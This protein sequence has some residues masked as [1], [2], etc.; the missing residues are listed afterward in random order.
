MFDKLIESEPAG[1]EFHGRK[2]Y[3]LVS[4]VVMGVLF[5]TAVVYSIYA[6]DIGLGTENFYLTAMIAPVPEAE[7]APEIERRRQSSPASTSTSAVP[8]RKSVMASID[9]PTIAPDSVSVSKNTQLAR[10]TFGDYKIGPDDYEPGMGAGSAR[11]AGEP[12][13]GPP[14]ALTAARSAEIEPAEVA[15]PPPPAKKVDTKPATPSLGVINGRASYL[16]KPVYSAA[17][18][19][20]Q[21]KGKVDVQVLIDEEGKVVSAKAVSGHPLLRDAAVKAAQNARFTP[22]LLSRVPIKVTGVIV[23]NFTR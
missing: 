8:M 15:P 23:Y 14:A 22:T 2:R 6:G 11:S 20:V 4:S 10:P 9:D 21:A 17:A 18:I 3:F 13:G 5:T 7:I 16:P 12:G 1:A 19:A